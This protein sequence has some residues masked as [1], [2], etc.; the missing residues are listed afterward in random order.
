M[1]NLKEVADKF[2]H[3]ENDSGSV[4]VQVIALTDRIKKLTEHTKANPKDYST[5]LGVIKLVSRRKKYL[6]YIKKHNEILY[7][8][9]IK[10]LGLRK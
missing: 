1:S 7:K 3:H 8:D 5:K 10:D 6:D 9:L 4:E 2:K